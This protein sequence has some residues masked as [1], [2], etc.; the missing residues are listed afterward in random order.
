ELGREELSSQV[1]QVAESF[2]KS[3]EE[4]AAFRSALRERYER[5]LL[6]LV[7]AVAR[8]ILH[9]E[10][11]DHPERWVDLIRAGVER[12]V[13]RDEIVVRVPARLAAYLRE[14]LSSLRS[15][16]DGVKGVELVEDPALAT[17][18]C[19]I[20][21]RFGEADVG[22]ETQLKNVTEALTAGAGGAARTGRARRGRCARRPATRAA[23]PAPAASWRH[24]IRCVSAAAS[25]TSSGS[26][27][28]PPG[29]GLRWARSAA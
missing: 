9:H 10:L 29:P 25:P 22:V 1:E 28:R 18:G 21:S 7:F 27:S 17:H 20:E 8:R 16:L 19:V 24:S 3:L 15:A 13:E 4:L 6:D 12:L 26:S 5:E 11:A 14:Q 2:V 23:S